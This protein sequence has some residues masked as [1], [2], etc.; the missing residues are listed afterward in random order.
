MGKRKGEKKEDFRVIT[1]ER[2][3]T[4]PEVTRIEEVIKAAKVYATVHGVNVYLW[5]NGRRV[6]KA[7]S[8]RRMCKRYHFA[9]EGHEYV[10]ASAGMCFHVKVTPD[11]VYDYSEES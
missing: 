2:P 10:N 9:L 4:L 5:I 3:T 6:G 11:G 8:R 7:K 1:D